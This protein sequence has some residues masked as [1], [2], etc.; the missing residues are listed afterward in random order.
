MFMFKIDPNGKMLSAIPVVG[1]VLMV[2]LPLM[3]GRFIC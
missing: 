3:A 2:F 1:S